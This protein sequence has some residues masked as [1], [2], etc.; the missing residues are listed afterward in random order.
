M[1]RVG[2]ECGAEE[3]AVGTEAELAWLEHPAVCHKQ[4]KI[5]TAVHD[6]LVRVWV[7]LLKNAGFVDVKLEDRDWD[8][9]GH[10]YVPGE[11]QPGDR[12]RPD[13]TCRDPRDGS[14]WIFDATICWREVKTKADGT[15]ELGAGAHIKEQAKIFAYRAGVK[16][17]EKQQREKR[18]R[19][20]TAGTIFDEGLPS[21]NFVP[22][23]FEIGGSWGPQAQEMLREVAECAR[24]QRSVELYGWAAATYTKHWRQRI[25][26][27]LG[28]GRAQ[29]ISSA[30]TDHHKQSAASQRNGE[31]ADGGRRE[32]QEHDPDASA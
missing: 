5:W 3:Y 15:R 12:R 19:L 2:G 1:P 20:G 27:I 16:R 25:G 14:R 21:L 32:S 8:Q 6:H 28:R 29:V 26:C 22:L 17:V 24:G 9:E 18:E 11:Y 13:I 10:T 31:S 4:A 30:V 23:G 7:A